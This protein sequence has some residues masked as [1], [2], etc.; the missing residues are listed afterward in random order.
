MAAP[1]GNQF[2][3]IRSK[4]GRDKLFET[5]DLLEKAACEYFEWC[6]EN[7]F[8]EEQIINKTSKIEDPL[9]GGI[10]VLPYTK[11]TVAKMRPFTY[12]GL[13]RY[14]NC[15]TS[16][17]RAFKSQ[18]REG[19]EDFITVISGIEET[20]RNQQYSGSASG[21]LNANIVSRYLGLADK[22]KTDHTTN[23]KDIPVTAWVEKTKEGEAK[24]D[25]FFSGE[26]K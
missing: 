2:W 21:F 14:L 7:P 24:M 1:K 25:Q 11:A 16:Y 20:I 22:T 13:C 12:E 6:E 18:K 19:A 9:T 5:P 4:H 23:G 10:I 15:D 8:Q 3:K 26:Q 17:F